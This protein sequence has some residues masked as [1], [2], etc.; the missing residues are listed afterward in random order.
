MF[1]ETICED[2]NLPLKDFVP[3]IATAIRERLREAELP[4]SSTAVRQAEGGEGDVGIGE[5]ELAWWRRHRVKSR[6]KT[7]PM[8]DSPAVSEDEL[9]T[10][11]RLQSMMVEQADFYD[12]RIRIQLDIVSGTMNLQDAFEWDLRSGTSPEEFAEVYAADLGLNGEF[13]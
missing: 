12:L 7:A 1:A 5:E 6:E 11:D 2:L 8:G 3:R 4:A 13:K 9:W 10:I